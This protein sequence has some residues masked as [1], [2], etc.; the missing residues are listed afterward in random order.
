MLMAERDLK[1]DL[2]LTPVSLKTFKPAQLQHSLVTHTAY[3]QIT[4]HLDS[5]CWMGFSKETEKKTQ[6]LQQVKNM[7]E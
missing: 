2:V 6:K 5:L 4:T 7:G 1:E 3:I